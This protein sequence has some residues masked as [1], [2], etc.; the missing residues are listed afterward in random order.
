MI[1]I[2]LCSAVALLALACAGCRTMARVTTLDDPACRATTTGAIA[3]VLR[4]QGETERVDELA[5]ST[6]DVLPALG[7]RPFLVMA[8]SGTDFSFFVQR[9]DDACLLRLYAREKGFT[10]YANDLTFIETRPLPGCGCAE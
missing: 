9:K 5:A 8:Q 7:P 6:V 10:S 2:R 4:A 3:D 1:G